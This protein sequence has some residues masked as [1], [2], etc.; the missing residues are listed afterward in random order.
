MFAC[1]KQIPAVELYKLAFSTKETEA[2]MEEMREDGAE[3]CFDDL[4]L[5]SFVIAK[6][7]KAFDDFWNNDW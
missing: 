2:C 5:S 3:G 7:V 1:V 6:D 4:L